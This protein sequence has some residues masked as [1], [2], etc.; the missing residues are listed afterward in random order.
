V[1]ALAGSAHLSPLLTVVARAVAPGI[2]AVA[3]VSRTS[4][5]AATW[6]AQ[7]GA[8]DLAQ[9]VEETVTGVRIVKGFGQES[10]MVARLEEL[11]RTLYARRLRAA[12]VNAR[13]APTLSALPQ[14][15]LVGVIALGGALALH[16]SLT[17]GTFLAF[18]TYITRMSAIARIIAG[19]L[20]MVQLSRAA[21]ERVFDVIDARP[22]IEDPPDPAG[23]PDGPVGVEM[24][25]VGFSYDPG[26]P[27]FDGVDLT[28]EPGETLVVVG[29]T[30]SGKSALAQLID[31]FYDPDSGAVLFS[32]GG[33]QVDLRDLPMHRVREVAAVVFDEPFLFSDSIAAN[34][35]L[36]RPGATD[37]EIRTAAADA[38][39][40]GFIAELAEGYA[41]TV[42]ERGLTLAGGQ[43]QRSALARAMLQ[44]PR[45]L[46][47]DDA[48]SAVDAE[49]ESRIFAALRAG[50]ADRTT[51]VLAH[52]R[53]TL[54]LA[55]RIA[56]LDG[57]RIVDSGTEAEL[58]RRSPLF[59][60]LIHPELDVRTASGTAAT[61]PADPPAASLWPHNAP[62]AADQGQSGDALGMPAAT[63]QVRSALDALPPA[64]EDPRMD[65]RDLRSPDPGFR[66]RRMLGPVAPLLAVVALLLA[67]DTGVG[68]SFPIIV[69]FAIDHGVVPHRPA[70]LYL[71]ALG[72]AAVVGVNWLVVSR[73]TLLT[74][75]AG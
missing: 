3:Y 61:V 66:L 10:R 44:D 25:G 35:A 33:A 49:T 19:M 7:Q 63:P 18:A 34:I 41:T 54:A 14:L 43:R 50:R 20:V 27:V 22:A 15:G 31:S 28:V 60:T 51:I 56:V 68:L 16:G 46:V 58:L 72:A 38:D 74:A 17:I 23:L 2:T 29:P 24:R 52:R 57:G 47:L 53:S 1:L 11:G 69:R 26:R 40:D 71:T 5:H 37:E 6:S 21:A 4:M 62:E 67:L 55:D 73:M 48:T 75:R 65:H 9:H 64:T 36:G 70:V 59:R 32:A 39:A 42:G 12:R 13:F 45:V 30:G 8:A